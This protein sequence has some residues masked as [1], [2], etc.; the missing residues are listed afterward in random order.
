MYVLKDGKILYFKNSKCKKNFLKLKRVA[1][2]VKW[3]EAY[4]KENK[5]GE[6]AGKT[7]KKAGKKEEPK[8]EAKE[9][10]KS[11]KPKAEE[12]PVQEAETKG[13]SK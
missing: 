4:R 8:P 10:P 12:K 1:R 2:K 13:E 3:T 6:H 11:V 7:E 9:E 5:K